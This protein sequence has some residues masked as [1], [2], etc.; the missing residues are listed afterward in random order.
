MK[1]IQ[2]VVALVIGGTLFACGES[3]P[4]PEVEVVRP[5]KILEIGAAGAGVEREYPGTARALQDA[6][7]GF[8]VPGRIIEL[9]AQEGAEVEAGDVLGKLD[10]R[11]YQSRLDVEQ[12]RLNNARTERDR[13]TALFAEG[14][15]A[16]A[17]KERRDRQFEAAEAN[18]AEAKKALDDT[19]LRAP[20]SGVIGIRHVENFQNVAA[21]EPVV[22]LQGGEALKLE[23]SL[24]E[25]DIAGRRPSG[26]LEEA[27]QLLRPRVQ[28]TAI[29]DAEFPARITEFATT[30][31]PN[32]RTYKVTMVFDPGDVS[33]LPGMTARVIIVAPESIQGGGGPSVP[34]RAVI[35]DEAGEAFVWRI[36]PTTMRAS[37]LPV[38]TGGMQGDEIEIQGGLEA[39]EWIATSG[40]HQ[41]REGMKVSRLER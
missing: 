36:D 27:N 22:F 4:P 35:A 14:V 12:A 18:F 9:S 21:K 15:T 19:I 34:A 26:T 23:V 17:E 40:V 10:P 11:D 7:L 30:A 41:I 32:T 6:E 31:D 20:F 16:K 37:R 1:K 13:Q 5:V 24:P 3:E 25:R 33:V 2:R 38:S 8:E 29:E 39:G 28:I